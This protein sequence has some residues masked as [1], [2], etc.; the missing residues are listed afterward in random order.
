MTKALASV[1]PAAQARPQALGRAAA[2]AIPAALGLFL[3]WGVGFAAPQAI[4][5]AA[6]DSRHSIAFP[7]H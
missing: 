3:I 1:R 4:H 7:C 6:H 2:I 5:D